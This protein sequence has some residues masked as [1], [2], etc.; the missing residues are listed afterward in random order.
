M[1]SFLTTLLTTI[2]MLLMFA[3]RVESTQKA[4]PVL[5]SCQLQL[6]LDQRPADTAWEIRGPFPAVDLVASRDYDYYQ[7]LGALEQEIVKLVEGGT[8]HVI[9]TDYKSDGIDNGG[10]LLTQQ[11][12]NDDYS[13]IN[14][15]TNTVATQQILAQ[16]DGHFGAGQIYT[17]EVPRK[18]SS[19]SS[20]LWCFGRTSLSL[21]SR[22]A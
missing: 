21:L 4:M 6:Q 18:A 8:Y 3:G 19:S 11:I 2:A 9:L 22:G 12:D 7:I 16:G 1:P 20:L 13:N 15:D 17:F 14:V 10:F 5:S